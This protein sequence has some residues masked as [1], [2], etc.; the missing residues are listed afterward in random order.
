KGVAFSPDGRLLA[1]CSGDA[2]A[3]GDGELKVWDARTGQ[4]LLDLPRHTRSV[5]CVAFSPDGR[6]LASGSW[7]QT[8]KIWDVAS[9]QEALTLR[10]HTGEVRSVVFSPDGQRLY[11]CAHDGT[12]RVWDATPLG[13]QEEEN[14]L[15][16]RGHS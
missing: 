5:M 15:T 10:S 8:V 13:H 4:E 7:D 14:C 12:V 16:L 1:S 9:G 2:T 6:R 11:S 3:W